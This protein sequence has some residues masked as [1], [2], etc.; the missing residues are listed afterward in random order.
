[1]SV[2]FVNPSQRESKELNCARLI[3]GSTPK[4][5]TSAR[6]PPQSVKLYHTNKVSEI[7]SKTE[8]FDSSLALLMPAPLRSR[9]GYRWLRSTAADFALVALNWLLLGSLLVPLRAMFPHL[10]VFAA[11]G[12]PVWLLGIAFLHAALITLLGYSEGLY[13]GRL[14]RTRQALTLVKA[15]FW[16]TAVLCVAYGLQ[17][18]PWTTC[19]L[20][21]S[22]G[23]LHVVTLSAWRCQSG[24]QRKEPGGDQRNTLIVGA[25][26]VGRRVAS[27]V[28]AHPEGGRRICGLLD[29]ER[30]LGNGIVGRVNDLARLA[31]T[32][33]ADEVILA[34]PHDRNLA[35]HVLREATRLQL[36]VEIIP[37][38]FGCKPMAGELESVGDL[39]AIC[40]HAERLPALALVLKRAVDVAGASLLLAL[41][42]P[43]LAAI[44]I[45]IKLDSSGPVLYCAPRAGRK[46]RLFRCHKFRTM[47]ADAD[48]LKS[49]LREDNQRS[50]PFFKIT[51]DPRITRL[52]RF[53]RRY[54][55]DEVPQLWNVLKGDMSLVGPR[56]HPLDDVAAYEPE[57]LAR[58]DV[59]PGMTGLWQVTARR[60]PSFQRGMEL[61]REYIRTWSLRSDLR[62]LGRTFL[63]VAR[64]SGE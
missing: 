22:A 25:G 28:A 48:R 37:E 32:E 60:D 35:I 26:A 15:V 24:L 59:T 39:P 19:V 45:M 38:L 62:I 58:L 53:L 64:G 47:V 7:D 44:A 16:A 6:K 42:S 5:R 20:F 17:G 50:G 29:N 21:S 36:D 3:P 49:G 46:G 8:V 10:R 9:L 4:Y 61:D 52:G 23:M 40:L 56:P 18:F 30:P 2:H 12:A 13:A 43:V 63:A 57:H 31:R 41:F 34:A 11:A 1:M 27:Y 33:F 55:I 54:S 51:N 14:D